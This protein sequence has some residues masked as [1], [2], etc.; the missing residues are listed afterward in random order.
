MTSWFFMAKETLALQLLGTVLEN[1]VDHTEKNYH[2][3][4]Y[5]A[6]E[7]ASELVIGRRKSVF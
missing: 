7:L 6:R 1:E 3:G 2:R 4:S 5:V